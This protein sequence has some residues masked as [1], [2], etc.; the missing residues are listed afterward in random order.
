MKTTPESNM[1]SP[2]LHPGST[3][4]VQRG[5]TCAILD[6]NHGYVAPWSPDGWWI[7]A[8]CPLHAPGE[9]RNDVV[10]IPLEED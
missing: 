5:C 6:N 10:Q 4:S 8:G 3:E 7:T 9:S 2:N 1:K